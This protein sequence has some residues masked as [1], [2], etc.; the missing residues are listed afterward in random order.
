M[1]LGLVTPTAGTATIDGQPYA[2]L[3]SPLRHVGVEREWGSPGF[4][5]DLNAWLSPSL[6]DDAEYLRVFGRLLRLSASP[7]EAIA[8]DRG[9]R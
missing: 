3:A 6:A 4:V 9:E 8:R 2:E 5:K 1:L 7:G